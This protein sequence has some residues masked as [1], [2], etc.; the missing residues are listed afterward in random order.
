MADYSVQIQSILCNYI[1]K[2]TLGRAQRSVS[3]AVRVAREFYDLTVDVTF[4]YGDTNCEPFLSDREVGE[5]QKND[6]RDHAL[7]YRFFGKEVGVAKGYN[8]L[9]SATKSQFVIVINP[10]VMLST[11]FFVYAFRQFDNAY[12]GIAEARQTPIEADKEYDI[13]T[14]ETDYASMECAI[15]SR[16]AL[17]KLNGLDEHFYRS[18]YDVDFSW[19]AKMAGY[20]TVYQ[21]L[22]LFHKPAVLSTDGK[23]VSANENHFYKALDELLVTY[24]WSNNKS[25]QSILRKLEESSD[26]NEQRA[27]ETFKKMR[28]DNVL[29]NRMSENCPV[30]AFKNGLICKKRFVLPVEERG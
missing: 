21:P 16:T 30:G 6:A 1:D 15:I 23:L 14:F 7:S 13:C 26:E 25:V 4:V 18:F 28:L 3:N 2:K 9:F 12:T 27:A 8:M 10:N 19:R 11:D 20:S 22:A 29:L 17:E 5:M 24:K